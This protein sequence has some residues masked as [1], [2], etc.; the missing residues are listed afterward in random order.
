MV[1]SSVNTDS[2]LA[3]HILGTVRKINADEYAELKESGYGITDTIGESGIEAA[4]EFFCF[5]QVL[6]NFR[7]NLLCCK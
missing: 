2:M 5:L 1:T 4:L 7:N 6:N 3:P